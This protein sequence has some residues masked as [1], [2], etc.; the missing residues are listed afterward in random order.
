MDGFEFEIRIKPGDYIPAQQT[1]IDLWNKHLEDIK[2]GLNLGYVTFTNKRPKRPRG[3]T[4]RIAGVMATSISYLQNDRE[5]IKMS[6][7][8]FIYLMAKMG[9]DIEVIE[10]NGNEF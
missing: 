2:D 1:L 7:E 9:I 3:N 4:R 8:N 6:D 5:L 10:K